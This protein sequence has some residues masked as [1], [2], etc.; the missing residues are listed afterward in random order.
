VLN[1]KFKRVY[2]ARAQNGFFA[3]IAAAID[4]PRSMDDVLGGE[5]ESLRDDRFS[6]FYRR[7]IVASGLQSVSTCR[8]ENRTANTA[9]HLERRV[10]GVYDNVYAEFRNIVSDNGKWHCGSPQMD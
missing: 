5:I 6:R 3:L 1:G 7:E 8:I 10:G 4:R 9:A 2:V